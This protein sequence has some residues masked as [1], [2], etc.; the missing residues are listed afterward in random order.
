MTK[1]G[2]P[3]RDSR[4]SSQLPRGLRRDEAIRSALQSGR[5]P[6]NKKRSA[7]RRKL[8]G[9]EARSGGSLPDR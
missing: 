4:G 5:P 7:T 8:N 3:A 6:A 9:E 2:L 1:N